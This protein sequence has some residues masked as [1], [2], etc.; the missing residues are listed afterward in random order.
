M[1][2]LF[3]LQLLGKKLKVASY[4]QKRLQIMKNKATKCRSLAKQRNAKE[5]KEVKHPSWDYVQKLKKHLKHFFTKFQLS[6][7]Y[8]ILFQTR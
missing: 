5:L 4:R 6:T 8:H 2:K 7:I 1:K 3:S